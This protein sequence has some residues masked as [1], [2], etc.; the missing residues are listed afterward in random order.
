VTLESGVEFLDLLNFCGLPLQRGVSANLMYGY[1]RRGYDNYSF[2]VQES[3]RGIPSC[4][5][6]KGSSAVRME[7]GLSDKSAIRCSSEFS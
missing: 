5:F 2:V 4:N 6:Q 7:K 1:R 3:T